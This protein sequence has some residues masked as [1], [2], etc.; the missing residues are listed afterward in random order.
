[1][2]ENP[3]DMLRQELDQRAQAGRPAQ[4]WLRD[5]DATLPTA[6]LDRLLTLTGQFEVPLTLA[7]IPADTG[8]ALAERLDGE[9]QVEVAVHGWSHHNHAADGEKSQE[10]GAHRPATTVLAELARGRERLASLHGAHFI[11]MLV[12]PWNRIANHVV[13]GLADIGYEALSVYGPEKPAPLPVLNTHVDIIDW[14]GTRGGRAD[15]VLV[16]ELLTVLRS[17]DGPIGLLIHHLVHDEAAWG[18]MARIFAATF[19]HKGCAWRSARDLLQIHG[20]RE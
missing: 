9:A 7:V 14:R 13:A 6:S 5:D 17:H 12:P 10:L 18:F 2:I 8:E 15:D 4:L 20:G 19:A 1:M 16:A 11:P 3:M